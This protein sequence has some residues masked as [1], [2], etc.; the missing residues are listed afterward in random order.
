MNL[1]QEGSDAVIDMRNA[2]MQRNVSMKICSME[3]LVPIDEIRS[4]DVYFMV[5]IKI[6]EH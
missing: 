3:K 2:L 4:Q 5:R 6:L 1:K